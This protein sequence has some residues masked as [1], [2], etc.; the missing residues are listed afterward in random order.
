MW[1]KAL[2]FKIATCWI[3]RPCLSKIR[4]PTLSRWHLKT[5]PWKKVPREL[6]VLHMVILK[7]MLI[8]NHFLNDGPCIQIA[9][10]AYHNTPLSCLQLNYGAPV[11]C[12]WLLCATLDC[13]SSCTWGSI[14]QWPSSAW[15]NQLSLPLRQ[16][17]STGLW[18]TPPALSTTHMR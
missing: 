1:E 4:G 9:T 18:I 6:L 17:Q 7:L 15:T 8:F 3:K 16:L 10:F 12:G 11:G 2:L 14:C 13:F 5:V